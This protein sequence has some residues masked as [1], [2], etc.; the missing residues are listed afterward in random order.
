MLPET[1]TT[2]PP[3]S[4]FLLPF[5]PSFFFF[6]PFPHIHTYN[7]KNKYS[8]RGY[9]QLKVI[10]LSLLQRPQ[11]CSISQPLLARSG[12][13]CLNGFQASFYIVYEQVCAHASTHTPEPE[14]TESQSPHTRPH[15][16]IEVGIMPRHSID[17]EHPWTRYKEGRLASHSP[18]APN[19]TNERPWV[20]GR[21]NVSST[22]MNYIVN[23]GLSGFRRHECC[24]GFLFF[25]G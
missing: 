18:L 19:T 14:G 20:S 10:S 5:F 9:T 8:V 24:L 17:Q 12:F 25:S 23:V 6:F 21:Q 7:S 1:N 16:V 11:G 3:A 22:H 15:T 13:L 4:S 2:L